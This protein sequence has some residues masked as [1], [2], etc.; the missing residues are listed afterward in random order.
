VKNGNYD[1][2]GSLTLSLDKS[3]QSVRFETSPTFT[4]CI[5]PLQPSPLPSLIRKEDNTFLSVSKFRPTS[6]SSAP[7]LANLCAIARPIPLD[8]P[9][10]RTFLPSKS[11][12]AGVL[13]AL[14]ILSREL[15]WGKL[16]GLGLRGTEKIE[17]VRGGITNWQLFGLSERMIA[18]L[19]FSRNAISCDQTSC[20]RTGSVKVTF[21]T[22]SSNI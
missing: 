22:M 19:L 15:N 11:L 5:F 17:L 13:N 7:S 9:V 21:A 10:M 6:V 16:E 8:A 14:L 3:S 2:R 12:R 1:E 4:A 18:V 20:L